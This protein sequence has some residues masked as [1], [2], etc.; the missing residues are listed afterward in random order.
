MHSINKQQISQIAVNS[1]M[2]IDLSLK[3]FNF[4]LSYNKYFFIFEL[5]SYN[6]YYILL[7]Y[8]KLSN[9]NNV[10]ESSIN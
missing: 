5:Y 4:S 1:A 10:L 7:S 8:L 2:G 6:S 9:S 3:F